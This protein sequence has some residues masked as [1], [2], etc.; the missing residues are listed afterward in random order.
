M[1]R[2]RLNDEDLD[3]ILVTDWNW[4]GTC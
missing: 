3:E 2:S 1:D 4:L